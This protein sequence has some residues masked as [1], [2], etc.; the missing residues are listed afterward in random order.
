MKKLILI[1]LIYTLSDAYNSYSFNL[2]DVLYVHKKYDR[3]IEVVFKQKNIES[4][5][6]DYYGGDIYCIENYNKL[7]KALEENEN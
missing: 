1:L 5:T 7:I 4:V 2:K 3:Y 6:V